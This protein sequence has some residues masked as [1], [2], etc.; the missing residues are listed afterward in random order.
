MCGS[1]WINL[2]FHQPSAAAFV[3]DADAPHSGRV[4]PFTCASILELQAAMRYRKQIKIAV[5]KLR[6]CG[7]S[8]K[9]TTARVL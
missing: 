8:A 5:G 6:E 3:V 4:A 7:E 1:T 2:D 9:G